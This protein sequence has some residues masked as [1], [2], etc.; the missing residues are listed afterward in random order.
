MIFFDSS[1][2]YIDKATTTKAKIVAIEN[3]ISGLLS[4]ATKA[5]ANENISEYSLDDGQTIIREVYRSTADVMKSI[6]AFESL[7][8]YYV[9]KLN[10]R[11]ARAMDVKNFNQNRYYGR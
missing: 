8:S 11:V 9:N 2:I 5:A 7:K 3:V 10:G 1:Q 6:Q 4:I